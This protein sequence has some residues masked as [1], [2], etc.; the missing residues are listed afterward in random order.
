MRKLLLFIIL[1]VLSQNIFSQ[2][3]INDDNSSPDSSAMLDVKS[4]TSGLL[5]PRMQATERDNI[6]SPA[7]GLI[8]Y[9]TDDNNFYYFDGTNW[10]QLEISGNSW[11]LSGNSGTNASQFV[12]TTDAQPLIFKTAN[13]ERIRI[14]ENGVIGVNTTPNDDYLFS[15]EGNNYDRIG[16]FISTRTNS[17]D[18]GVYGDVSASDYYGYGGYFVGGFVGVRAKVVPAGGHSYLGVDASVVGGGGDNFGVYS[19]T[20]GS[21]SNYGMYTW[22]TGSG[23]NYG[24]YAN[25][26]GGSINYGFYDLLDIPYNEGAGG[27]FANENDTGIG[28]I[29]NGN[30][31]SSYYVPNHGAGL[32]ANGTYNSITGYSEYDDDSVAVIYGSYQGTTNTDATGVLGY[33]MPADD[34]GYGVKGYGGWIGVYGYAEDGLAGV[35]GYAAGST[36]YAVYANGDTG[37]S[38]TKSFV[39]DHPADP[40]NKYLK[41]FS[42]ESDEILNVY[43]GNV[44][45][46][47][48]G[49]AKVKL[50]GYFTLIN[51]NY[52]YQ[53]TPIGSAAPDI[54]VSNE[55]ND[56]GVFTISGGNPGQ[57]ISWYVFAE[58]NDP[59]LQK[60]PE[61]RKNE[62]YKKGKNKG[63]YL[64]PQIYG[65]P[66]SKAINYFENNQK[67]ISRL[68]IE[69][70]V[71]YINPEKK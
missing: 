36:N 71:P 68:K 22:T 64:M 42:I 38:G 12:G 41:H 50:P 69:K 49:N 21:G 14:K 63:K 47:Q 70:K 53:L 9:V 15:V 3:A 37:A 54:F 8:V 66:E 56:N 55:I 61:K 18:Y 6:S 40:A 29:V 4:T 28:A 23:N 35:Y 1:I 62:L 57:K 48:N 45:L 26:R 5:I 39:I 59:Y 67:N 17:D 27:Y 33:S 25:V 24:F 34:Y 44:I 46:D 19:T 10:V 51:K 58:R 20:S 52:S 32:V 7:T 60:F 2:V 30:N 16:S 43:R 13:T 31:L 11:L 65:Q